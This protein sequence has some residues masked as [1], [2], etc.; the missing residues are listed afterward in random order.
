MK[1]LRREN[2]GELKPGSVFEKYTVE[3]LLG[4]GGM[5]AVYLVRH[6]VLDTLFALKILFPEIAAVKKQFVD[7]F[8]REAKLACKIRH[9]NLIAVHDAGRSANGMYYIVMDYVPGGNV[10]EL[11]R[12]E[13]RLAPRRAQEIVLQVAGALDA[14]YEHHM[15]HRDIKPDNIMFAADGSAKL[16]D[17]GIAKSTDDQDTMLTM[18]ASVFG[19]PSYMSPEQ[20]KDS[21][22][23]DCRADIY[24]LGIVFYEM[25][26]GQRPFRGESSMQILSQVVSADEVPDVRTI[27]PELPPDL[28]AVVAGMTAKKLEERIPTPAVLLERLRAIRLPE[29]AASAPSGNATKTLAPAPV[30]VTMPTVASVPEVPAPA[31]EP[32]PAPAAPVEVTMA[33]VASV[34]EAPAP[35][36]A[37]KPTPPPVE[38][39]NTAV[40]VD[41]AGSSKASPEKAALPA[42]ER[43]AR[44][45]GA[46]K[47]ILLGAVAGF[48]CLIAAVAAVLLIPRTK[49][50]GNAPTAPAPAAATAAKPTETSAPAAATTKAT[51]TPSPIPT[52]AAKSTA[53]TPAAAP[54]PATKETAA[55]SAPAPATKETP[56]VPVPA[57][58]AP[59][60]PAPEELVSDPLGKGRIVL[61]GDTS[62]EMRSVREAMLRKFGGE[63]VSF[64]EAEGMAG[65][66]RQLERIIRS[67]PSAVILCLSRK[68]AEERTSKAGFENIISRYADR[69][70]DSGIPFGFLLSA[71]DGDDDALRFCN[72]AT[73]ELCKLRSI[74]RG[75]NDAPA[76]EVPALAAQLGRQ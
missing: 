27:R 15:V 34:P 43:P 45:G 58:P 55:A 16:A 69:L 18:A 17:L 25:L 44:R 19:T 76:A 72:E 54:S 64:Q 62:A 61:L 48:V 33:T 30:E 2:K 5:G 41:A 4:R 11:L 73:A 68:Y 29:N 36:P 46:K 3:K 56:A 37:P 71:E 8:I 20:A 21:S 38:A 35:A 24:S 14:A 40:P 12:R 39:R 57:P 6:N 31:P 10:R 13:G 59:P 63:K 26:T 74:P 51:E 53:S 65:Y 1:W 75:G 52:S 22:K 42:P 32:A 67:S 49:G 66:Q 28:A 23:V 47:W 60:A 7:R 70:R 50:A 9:P